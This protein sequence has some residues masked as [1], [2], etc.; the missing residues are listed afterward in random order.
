MRCF[1]ISRKKKR[2]LGNKTEIITAKTINEAR[3]RLK[4]VVAIHA[5]ERTGS[6]ALVMPVPQKPGSSVLHTFRVNLLDQLSYC[7]L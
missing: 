4:F 2:N 1:S 5:P 3:G 6:L 7:I